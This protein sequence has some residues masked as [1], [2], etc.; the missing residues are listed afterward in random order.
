MLFRL[1]VRHLKKKTHL[2]FHDDFQIFIA[3]TTV[4]QFVVYVDTFSGIRNPRKII[5]SDDPEF[6]EIMRLRD[7]LNSTRTQR[8]W[9][10]YRGIYVDE[11][12]ASGRLVNTR[13]LDAFTNPTIESFF[14]N[15]VRSGGLGRGYGYGGGAGGGYGGYGDGFNEL[16]QHLFC[17]LVSRKNNQVLWRIPTPRADI[18]LS[19]G[20]FLPQSSAFL[21][22]LK[23]D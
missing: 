23:K 2:F 3:D 17:Q 18:T 9:L 16:L 5:E 14:V 21:L 6:A 4:T 20:R 1:V 19:Q 10:G 11:L 8:P 22:Y 13:S 7:Q 15:S 12:T